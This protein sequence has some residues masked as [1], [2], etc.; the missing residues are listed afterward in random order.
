MNRKLT[1][2]LKSA[3]GSE[4]P[5]RKTAFLQQIKADPTWRKLHPFSSFFGLHPTLM[6]V[7]AFMTAAAVCALIMVFAFRGQSSPKPEEPPEIISKMTVTTSQS[8]ENV[9]TEDVTFKA[10]E[11]TA[12]ETAV[13]ISTVK[14]EKNVSSGTAAKVPSDK[15]ENDSPVASKTS[16][17]IET[18]AAVTTATVP[19]ETTVTSIYHTELFRH[20]YTAAEL[21]ADETLK[22][23]YPDNFL[24][25]EILKMQFGEDVPSDVLDDMTDAEISRDF[26]G[27]I[28]AWGEPDIIEGVTTGI[29]YIAYE[30]RPWTICEVTVSKVHHFNCDSGNGYRVINK[31]D[32]VKIAMPGGYMALSEYIAL[33]PD[34]TQFEGWTEKRINSTVIY[35]A[36]SNQREPKIGD[37]FAYF[38]ENC[39]LDIPIENLY[40]R[41]GFNDMSQFMVDGG[42]FVSCNS[43]YPDYKFTESQVSEDSIWEYFYDPDSD[44]GIAFRNDSVLLMGYVSCYSIDKDGR[45]KY[46]DGFGTDDGF[47][48]FYESYGEEQVYVHNE[49]SVEGKYYQLK[50]TDEGVTL[51][52]CFDDLHPNDEFKTINFTF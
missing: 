26:I 41:S 16:V 21:N 50:W 10:A 1:K 42:Y 9:N 39:E 43:H 7:S 6:P 40:V 17:F 8:P 13:T 18:T 51:K 23:G 14:A 49:K 22:Y 19:A 30:G 12:T 2:L 5:D 46:L 33:N 25:R 20:D 3:Y 15:E 44:R 38:L 4:S 29:E 35:E 37:S 36:G 32:K 27:L 28:L 48:P 47:F 52:Y 11:N 24:M 45:L 34:D 31:G